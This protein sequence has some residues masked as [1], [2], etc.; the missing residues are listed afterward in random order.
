MTSLAQ[1]WN[2]GLSSV[3]PHR[4]AAPQASA[5]VLRLPRGWPDSTPLVS[6]SWWGGQG[7]PQH[8]RDPLDKIPAHDRRASTY[9]WT[10]AAQTLLTEI[11]AP[12]RAR[13]KFMQALPYALEEQLLSDPESAHFAVQPLNSGRYAVAV[14]ARDRLR[15]WLE[16]LQM[17]GFQPSVLCPVTLAVP[18]E[19]DSWC[20]V[21]DQDEVWLRTGEY[22]G[23]ACPGTPMQ[24]LEIVKAVLEETRREQKAP[25]QL[26]LYQPPQELDV[27]ALAGQL[28]LGIHVSAAE[29]SPIVSRTVP[30]MNLRQGEFVGDSGRL[31]ES[32]RALKPAGILVAIWLLASFI[33]NVVEWGMLRHEQTALRD[34]MVTLFRA[35]FPDAQA[36]EYPA[37]QMERNHAS[38]LAGRGAHGG[39][40]FLSIL[41][42]VAPAVTGDSS[43]TLRSLRYTEESLTLTL[44]A[45]TR[46]SLETL[47]QALSKRGFQADVLETN[48]ERG[49]IVG[50]LR[51][52]T[53]G[54]S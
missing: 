21:W 53:A 41:Q 43:I 7:Q 22:A 38:L 6:W 29:H 39:D 27:A 52:K 9:V 2:S 51:I 16:R 49:R 31:R 50:R 44:D 15:L 5:W 14:T 26:T 4:G 33:I 18:C 11:Q 13:S 19:P 35:T 32:A 28:E 1:F 3:R 36:F 34:E 8:G 37:L 20:L 25:S 45:A 47:R 30:A 24:S 12:A 46:E 23:L 42:R 54:L 17:A 48:S 40:E 10:P